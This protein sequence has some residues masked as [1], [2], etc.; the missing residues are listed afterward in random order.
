[1]K[2]VFTQFAEQEPEAAETWYDSHA[3]GMGRAF[4]VA[5]SLALRRVR[6]YPN[7]APSDERGIHCALVSGFPYGVRYHL[8][9]DLVIVLAISHTHRKPGYWM[10]RN[11]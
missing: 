11:D 5:V 8:E 2:V 6:N 9:A 4:I 7:A 1:M 3:S 10:D